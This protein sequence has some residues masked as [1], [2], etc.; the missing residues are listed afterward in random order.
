MKKFLI[1]LVAIVTFVACE[2]VAPNYCGVL[3]EN[4]FNQYNYE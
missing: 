2:R 3:M 1:F 4:Y